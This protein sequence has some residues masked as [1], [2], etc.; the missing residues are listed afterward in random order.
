M[1]ADSKYPEMYTNDHGHNVQKDADLTI[2]EEA[3]FYVCKKTL[4]LV[5]FM[6]L[7]D[8]KPCVFARFLDAGELEAKINRLKYKLKHEN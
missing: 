8:T 1:T 5:V 7:E 3:Y 4:T 6:K 2:Y